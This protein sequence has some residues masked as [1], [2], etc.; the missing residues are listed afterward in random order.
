LIGF[1]IARTGKVNSITF[2]D[3]FA[4]IGTQSG[5]SHAIQFYSERFEE[6][7]TRAQGLHSNTVTAIHRASNSMLWVATPMGLEYSINEEGDWRFIDREQLGL[8]LGTYIERIGESN[9][10]YG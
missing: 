9:I 8:S 1:N 7:I 5:G 2:G 10:I 4:Y 3:R 6:P